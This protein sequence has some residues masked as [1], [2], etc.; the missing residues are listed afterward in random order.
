MS[1]TFR[2]LRSPFHI[3]VHQLGDIIYSFSPCTEQFRVF[4]PT[5]SIVC[6]QS[7][8]TKSEKW[9]IIYALIERVITQAASKKKKLRGK[10]LSFKEW[11]NSTCCR[12][13]LFARTRSRR[14]N[15]KKLFLVWA[16]DIH[17]L[18]SIPHSE[19]SFIG[20]FPKFL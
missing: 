18:K 1:G 2:T 12:W 19:G 4:V 7:Q 20:H 10:N 13:H 15:K 8:R 17:L 9:K 5:H 6:V 16:P 11:N 3:R 14:L